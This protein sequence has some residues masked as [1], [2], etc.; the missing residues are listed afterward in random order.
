MLR[1]YK[2]E[3]NPNNKQVTKMKMN[4]GAAR[5]AFNFALNK[6]KEAFNKKEKIPNNIELHRELNKLKGTDELAWGYEVSKT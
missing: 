3:L 1:A 4:C 6:K 2:T 5:W